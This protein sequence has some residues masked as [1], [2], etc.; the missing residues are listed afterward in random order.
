MTCTVGIINDKK[1]IIFTY[2]FPLQKRVLP[3]AMHSMIIDH[4]EKPVMIKD[5][6]TVARKTVI[7]L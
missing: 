4:M 7:F 2:S 3:R 1:F 6:P 5:S